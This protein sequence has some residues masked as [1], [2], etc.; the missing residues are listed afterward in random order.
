MAKIYGVSNHSPDFVVKAL[1]KSKKVASA[2]EIGIVPLNS[3]LSENCSYKVVMFLTALDLRKN[4][5]LLNDKEC[6]AILFA[7]PLRVNELQ[8]VVPLDFSADPEYP[9]FGFNLHSLDLTKIS[10]KIEHT[11]VTKI[12]GNYL[13][14]LISYVQKG[15]LLNSLMTFIYTLPSSSQSLVKVAVVKWL[16]LNKPRSYLDNILDD[17]G[18]TIVTKKCRERLKKILFTEVGTQYQK[19]FI[20][21]KSMKADGKANLVKIAKQYG[22]SDYEMRYILS[23]VEE[24][25][26]AAKY[27]DSFE[28]ARNS[29]KKAA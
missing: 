28:K 24:S 12:N 2:S 29:R 4:L 15:S 21:Y 18:S 26:R 20:E 11:E 27:V 1:V 13:S 8:G 17:L 5:K 14:N 23:I 10:K 16:Y 22:V 3:E 9:G 19:A 6:I 7:N 25:K